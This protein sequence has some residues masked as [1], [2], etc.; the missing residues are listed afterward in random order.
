MRGRAAAWAA[1]LIPAAV[2]GAAIFCFV[3]DRHSL[4]GFPLDDAWIHRVYSRSVSQGDGFA[5]NEGVQEAGCTSPLWV[6]VT[7]PVHWAE[8]FGAD[9]VVLL[10]KLVGVLLGLSAVRAAAILGQRLSGSAWMG[11]VAA[12]LLALEPRLLFSALS[13]M[14]TM[15]LVAFWMWVCVALVRGQFVLALVLFSVL[16]VTRPEAVL[17]LPLSAWAMIGLIR[18]RGRGVLTVAAC[19]IPVVPVLLWM[20]FCHSVAGHWL[21]NTYYLKSRP[22]HLWPADLQMAWQ[23]LSQHGFA[24]LW[25]Y[26]FGLA[27]W[28]TL[29]R[30][31]ARTAAGICALVLLAAP[32]TYLL[33]VV[34]S[35]PIFLEGYYWT[36]WTDPAS[37][38]LTVPFCLGYGSVVCLVV[39]PE[40]ALR[41]LRAGW[42]WAVGGERPSV[43]PPSRGGKRPQAGPVHRPTPRDQRAAAA[44]RQSFSGREVLA[45]RAIGI[46]F[47]LLLVLSIPAFGRS[48]SDRLWHLSADAR[49]ID[50]MDVGMAKWIRE[51]SPKDAVVA[52]SDAG[53]LRYFGER[54]A[55]DISG[56][57]NSAIAFGR[58]S[59]RDVLA[60]SDWLAIFPAWYAPAGMLEEVERLFERRFEIRIP[61]GEYT[62]CADSSQLLMVAFQKRVRPFAPA[63]VRGPPP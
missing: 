12:S 41:S 9:R 27:A 45:V 54:R 46:A 42:Q 18:R 63:A 31:G 52:V 1:A 29:F 16:P 3:G 36:R 55:I 21:P 59:R 25:A 37:L 40:S 53:A 15:L 26:P 47:L 39:R 22:F 7:A 24:S 62:I 23:A 48:F 19:A 30:P 20:L 38:M 10:V 8:R 58:I 32:A 6:I 44:D 4:C 34:G 11:C 43:R 14:E 35:R 28:I 5:Y 57:N 51:H 49:C 56:L 2:Y 33:G 61:S 60:A 17:V 50:V 13:G